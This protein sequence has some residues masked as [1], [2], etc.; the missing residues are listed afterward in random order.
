MC[1]EIDIQTFFL[2]IEKY[3]RRVDVICFMIFIILNHVI[4][5]K[6]LINT[7]KAETDLSIAL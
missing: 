1:P 2:K 4:C 5:N 3:F 6:L 7:W